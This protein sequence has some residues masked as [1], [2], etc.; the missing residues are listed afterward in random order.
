MRTAHKGQ[1][2]LMPFAIL[3]TCLPKRQSTHHDSLNLFDTLF[4]M[5]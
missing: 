1:E 5:N 2:S 3:E 4:S